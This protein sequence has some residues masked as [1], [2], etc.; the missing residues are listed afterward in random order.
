[1]TGACLCID[2]HVWNDYVNVGN[3]ACSMVEHLGVDV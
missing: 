1:M 2:N 3:H